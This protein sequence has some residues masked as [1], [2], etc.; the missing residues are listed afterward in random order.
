MTVWKLAR[1]IAQQITQRLTLWGKPSWLRQV[2][3]T[4]GMISLSEAQ[5]LYD[6]ARRVDD[7]CIVEVGSYRGRSTSALAYGSQHGS[8]APIYAVEPHEPFD[9]VLGATFGPEDRRGFFCTMLRT[10]AYRLVRLLNAG[11]EVVTPGWQQ[12][13]ALLWL[14][15][16]HTY[17]G[18]KRDLDCWRPHLR[19]DALRCI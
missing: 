8:S 19:Q 13:V 2:L 14:D 17:E 7:G 10:S 1:R 9:G 3:R 5:T 4:P 16:D 6:L 12:P 18:V 15:G 11:S